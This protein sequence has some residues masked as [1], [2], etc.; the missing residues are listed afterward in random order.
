MIKKYNEFINEKLTDNLKGFDEQGILNQLI[1]GTINF[2]KYFELALKYNFDVNYEYLKEYFLNK[3]ID[4]Y[5][6]Y[7]AK[8]NYF[9][10][11]YPSIQYLKDLFLNGCISMDVYPNLCRELH[12][13]LPTK[14]DLYSAIS[15]YNDF[16][17]MLK[18]AIKYDFL[19]LV[20]LSIEKGADVHHHN[21]AYLYLAIGNDSFEVFKYLL[22]IGFKLKDINDTFILTV[23]SKSTKI[24]NYLY[25]KI[26][27]SLDEILQKAIQYNYIELA[28]FALNKNVIVNKKMIDDCDNNETKELLKKYYDKQ[29]D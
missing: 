25:D 17:Y 29:H 12:I 7:M 22:N 13:E 26:D 18:N 2:Y 15:N 9:Y 20:K 23:N 8:R 3:K 19:D 16:D 10:I 1:D 11:N 24:M 5:D 28:K 21:D 4:F 6:F 14:N 27:I